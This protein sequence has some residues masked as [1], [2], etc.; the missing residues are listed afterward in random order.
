MSGVNKHHDDLCVESATLTQLWAGSSFSFFLPFSPFESSP[1][2]LP[3]PPPPYH[4][5]LITFP[6]SPPP[7]LPNPPEIET[8]PRVDIM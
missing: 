5:P 6:L 4:L 8:L 7:P 2:P 1:S 3:L